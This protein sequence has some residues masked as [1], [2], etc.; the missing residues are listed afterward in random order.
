MH[1]CPYCTQH[2]KQRRVLPR[3]PLTDLPHCAVW[4]WLF[5]SVYG[6]QFLLMAAVQGSGRRRGPHQLHGWCFMLYLYLYMHG[7]CSIWDAALP[8]L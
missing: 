8:T 4:W 1:R 5:V 7:W 2:V 6:F 3:D